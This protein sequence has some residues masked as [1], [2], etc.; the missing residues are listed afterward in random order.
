MNV[1]GAGVHWETWE[2][3]QKTTVQCT[4]E[5]NYFHFVWS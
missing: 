5:E 1:N 2:K 4:T 3:I